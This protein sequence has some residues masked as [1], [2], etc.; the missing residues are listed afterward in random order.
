MPEITR[1]ITDEI[2]LDDS[3]TMEVSNYQPMYGSV[4]LADRY[5]SEQLYGQPWEVQTLTN[6]QKALMTATRA[7]DNL[8]FA[9]RKTEESQV[10]EFPRNDDTTVPTEVQRATFEEALALLN[11]VQSNTEYDGL[12]VSSRGFGK[13][14]TDYDFRSAPEHVV[15]GIASRAAWLL[16]QPFLAPAR[17][18]NLRRRS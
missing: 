15:A 7:I 10:L 9:G 17:S 12:F 11:G 13:V 5:F 14:R 16:L 18:I 1:T 6:K 4:A 2:D 8:R 3:L